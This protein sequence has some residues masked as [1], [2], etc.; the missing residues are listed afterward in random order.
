[1]DAS[2][3]YQVQPTAS[4]SMAQHQHQTRATSSPSHAA[5]FL[6]KE[7]NNINWMHHAK[8][9]PKRRR[10][11]VSLGGGGSGISSLS[12][13]VRS[14]GTVVV[15]VLV[16]GIV[17]SAAAAAWSG[18]VSTIDSA[19]ANV[20]FPSLPWEAFLP[21]AACTLVLCSYRLYAASCSCTRG[22]ELVRMMGHAAEEMVLVC[23]T[24]PIVR[25][26]GMELQEICRKINV[27]LAFV[28]QDLRESRQ[29]ED[30]RRI[31]RR[32]SPRDQLALQAFFT[33]PLHFAQDPYGAP[34]L[35][36]MLSQEEIDYYSNFKPNA[37]V[38]VLVAELSAFF[39]QHVNYGSAHMTTPEGKVFE[40]ELRRVRDAWSECS[41]I[42]KT[43]VPYALH[44]FTLVA[45]F[46]F[47][48]LVAPLYY[49][50]HDAVISQ[51][52]TDDSNIAADLRVGVWMSCPLAF[53]TAAIF[54]GFEAAAVRIEVPFGWGESDCNLTGMCRG[55]LK[56]TATLFKVRKA[57]DRGLSLAE[58][59]S[60]A[61]PLPA[62][63]AAAQVVDTTSWGT[64]AGG[65][66]GGW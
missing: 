19:G 25:E 5:G 58:G 16:P 35:I 62:G 24:S 22:K 49:A 52:R 65:S 57:I 61:S 30:S 13:A 50:T 3:S 12:S 17:A 43:P 10:R 45:M 59:S 48:I 21:L 20:G 51:L 11:K 40:R 66:G 31:F 27:L 26:S 56:N 64:A 4:V 28:R 63:N 36:A 33:T 38:L 6:E 2:R 14:R 37:R 7:S 47:A 15:Q 53:I 42:I 46:V 34:P 44:H 54:Y 1:M 41:W 23:V 55:V 32:G 9:K 8:I 39:K 60:G 18:V 29:H